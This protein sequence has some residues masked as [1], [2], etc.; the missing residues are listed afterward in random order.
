[1]SIGRQ[2]RMDGVTA[3]GGIVHWVRFAS[4]QSKVVLFKITI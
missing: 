1:M 4:E 3:I 2:L